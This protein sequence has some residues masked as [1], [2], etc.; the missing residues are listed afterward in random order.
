MRF[1]ARRAQ[2]PRRTPAGPKG[3]LG[4]SQA[5]GAAFNRAPAGERDSVLWPGKTAVGVADD[6]ACAED[7]RADQWT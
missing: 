3:W 7:L 4:L 2:L 6:V 5:E 1:K